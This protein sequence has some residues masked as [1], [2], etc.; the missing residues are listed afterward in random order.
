[1]DY[2]ITLKLFSLVVA[3]WYTEV[4]IIKG[5]FRSQSV[6]ARNFVIQALSIAIFVALQFNLFN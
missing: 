4:N 2:L 6:S 5:I 1:M 3:I